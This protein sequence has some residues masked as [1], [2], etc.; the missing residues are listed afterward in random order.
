L[1]LADPDHGG[2]A[3]LRR[4]RQDLLKDPTDPRAIPDKQTVEAKK[5]EEVKQG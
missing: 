4:P 1:A 5:A 2:C 3:S